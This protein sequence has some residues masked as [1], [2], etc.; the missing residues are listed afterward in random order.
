MHAEGTPLSLLGVWPGSQLPVPEVPLRA[1]ELHPTAPRVVVLRPEGVDFGTVRLRQTALP[2]ELY[3]RE[4]AD[5]HLGS[6]EEIV[7]F[8]ARWGWLGEP[9]AW[10]EPRILRIDESGDTH[11][12]S[13]LVRFHLLEAAQNLRPELGEGVAAELVQAG[14][15]ELDP[16]L[17]ELRH[18]GEFVLY[19]SVLRD[20]TRIYLA[21]REVLSWEEVLGRW[22]TRPEW[23]DFSDERFTGE[24][25]IAGRLWFFTQI[26][27]AALA[28]FR[29]QVRLLEQPSLGSASLAGQVHTYQALA[30]QLANHIAEVPQF[31]RCASETCGRL[32]VRQRG[33]S[34][35]GE[36]RSRGL[37]YCSKRCAQAEAQRRVRR[38][39]AEGE[40]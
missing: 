2:D 12:T 35:Y 40:A 28:P 9:R 14:A 11:M 33:A 1:V 10:I 8:T 34:Q 32:F 4:L 6:R 38:R 21:T 24:R 37:L 25:L 36:G 30:L 18:L 15:R 23:L 31:K 20:L 29:A 5:I 3:L 26:L 19:A 7:A 39:R 16:S 22:E 17:G 13:P 27:N